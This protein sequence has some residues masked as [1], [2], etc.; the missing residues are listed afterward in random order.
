M[1]GVG[2][3]GRLGV[4]RPKISI[5][6]ASPGASKTQDPFRQ[7]QV[8]SGRVRDS[9]MSQGESQVVERSSALMLSQSFLEPQLVSRHIALLRPTASVS[10]DCYRPPPSES[11]AEATGST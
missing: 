9:K 2:G 6:H 10:Q 7:W 11:R 3:G 1:T 5:N 8:K 4:K